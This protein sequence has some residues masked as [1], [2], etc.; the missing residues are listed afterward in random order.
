MHTYIDI[1]IINIKGDE[2]SKSKGLFGEV[3]WT[4]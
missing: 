4:I 3:P 2:C 1:Y